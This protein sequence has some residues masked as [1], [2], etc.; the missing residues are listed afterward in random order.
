MK[1]AFL[2]FTAVVVGGIVAGTVDVM[3][4]IEF[5]EHVS[6]I[7]RFIHSVTYII[8]GSVIHAAANVKKS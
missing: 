2:I 5:A 8:F 1:K 3:I 7:T 4:D 6:N